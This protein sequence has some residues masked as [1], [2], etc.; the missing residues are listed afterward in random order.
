L[1]DAELVHSGVDEAEGA[2]FQIVHLGDSL[3]RLAEPTRAGTPLSDHVAKWGNMIYSI[4]FQVV[5]LDSAEAWL[6]KKNVG[7]SRPGADLL[8][9][10]VADT[11]GAPF[12]F[13]T[14]AIP[15]D[16]YDA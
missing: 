11:F 14:A 9:A 12:F 7:T 10:D 6:A 13:T 3:L 1:F 16:P 4:T 5:D 8:A 15:G 2:K